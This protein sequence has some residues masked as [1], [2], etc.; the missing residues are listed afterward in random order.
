MEWRLFKYWRKAWC[1]HRIIWKFNL[2]RIRRPLVSPSRIGYGVG[3]GHAVLYQNAMRDFSAQEG[4][5]SVVK[6]GCEVRYTKRKNNELKVVRGAK[7]PG[8]QL[9]KPLLISACPPTILI[10]PTTPDFH[11]SDVSKHWWNSLAKCSVPPDA[12]S[13]KMTTNYLCHLLCCQRYVPHIGRDEAREEFPS[14]VSYRC[15]HME[16]CRWLCVLS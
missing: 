3:S 15:E 14:L 7:P 5:L 13:K 11:C 1:L 6:A 16:E 4:Q 9:E 2:K 10:E 12:D 8:E